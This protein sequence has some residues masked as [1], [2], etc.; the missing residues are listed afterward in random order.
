MNSSLGFQRLLLWKKP[1]IRDLSLLPIS[2]LNDETITIFF[3]LIKCLLNFNL[4][5]LLLNTC[6]CFMIKTRFRP[7]LLHGPDGLRQLPLLF[8]LKI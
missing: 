6:K 4:N 2:L 1:R 3:N 8:T 7:M 5:R